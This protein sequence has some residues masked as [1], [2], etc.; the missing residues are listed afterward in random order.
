MY[1]YIYIYIY[2]NNKCIAAETVRQH[3][4]GRALPPSL[5]GDVA[6]LPAFDRSGQKQGRTNPH[7][8]KTS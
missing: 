7:K 1:I 3:L 4:R 5:E 6:G 8:H 2:M